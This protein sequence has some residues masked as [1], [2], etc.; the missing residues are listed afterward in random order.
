MSYFDTYKKKLGISGNTQSEAYVKSTHQLIN[1]SFADSPTYKKI[2][3]GSNIYDVRIVEGEKKD[4]KKLLFRPDTIVTKGEYAVV[5]TDRWLL[6]SFD[7]NS[8]TPKSVIKIA[9]RTLKWKDAN[10]IVIEEPCVLES[11]QYEEMRDGVYFFTPKGNIIVHTQLNNRTES[12]I[13]N[14]RFIF[15]SSVFK[16]GG[17]DDFANV[18]LDKGYL[19]IYLEKTEKLQGDN[20][21]TGVADNSSIIISTTAPTNGGGDWLS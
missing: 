6:L 19:T 18:Y 3:I 9:D 7:N 15:G 17:I 14:Q 2:Y 8:I 11:T 16:I 5:D 13:E 12:L 1:D 10:G 21:V 20:F 4:E